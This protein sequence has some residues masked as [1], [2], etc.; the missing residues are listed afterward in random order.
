[1]PRAPTENTD[2]T[3]QRLLDAAGEVFAEHGFNRATVRDICARAGAN[4]AA[5][6]YHFGDKE[7]LYTEVLLFAHACATAKYPSGLGVPDDAPPA[8]RLHA[9]VLSFL[10]RLFDQGR[11][12]WHLRI[13]T[14]EMAEPTGAMDKLVDEQIRPHFAYVRQVMAEL[15]GPRADEE[16]VRL[17]CNSV[18]G[19]CLF[20][21]FAQPVTRRLFHK[22]FGMA[23]AEGMARHITR[24]S[25]AGVREIAK[26]LG[27]RS[28]PSNGAGPLSR[29]RQGSVP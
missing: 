4:V 2:K 5:V 1:M 9:F 17:C 26:G 8:D 28:R 15:L 18:V 22:A 24:L 29:K 23:D 20:Y 11:P 14:R 6:K 25:L 19:Q 21:H 10:K 12:A 3:C 13:V 27:D 16:S 7:K